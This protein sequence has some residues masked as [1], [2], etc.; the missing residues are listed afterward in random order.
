MLGAG[1]TE[2]APHPFLVWVKPWQE[3]AAEARA[4]TGMATHAAP[5]SKLLATATTRRP[6]KYTR[7]E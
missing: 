2:Q 4:A 5:I 1:E 6:V 7:D 3:S